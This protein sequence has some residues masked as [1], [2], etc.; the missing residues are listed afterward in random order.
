MNRFIIGLLVL[1]LLSCSQKEKL[2]GETAWQKKMNADFKDASKSPLKKKDLKNFKSLD[3]FPFDS[4]YVVR[5]NLVRTPDSEWFNMKTSTG[6]VTVERIYGVLHF[7][8][9]G[10]PF[11]LNVYE[12][13]ESMQMGRFN[14]YLF[15]PFLDDTNGNTTYAGGR[16]INLQIPDSN[17][18]TINFNMAYSP[19]CD[20]NEKYSCP[21]VPRVNYLPTEVKA[22]VKAYKKN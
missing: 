6:D 4:S 2:L 11:Q 21:I 13:Q 12:G 22:G 16:Y 18:I 20:Y 5:A 19:Y 15:L 9:N 3:F 7:N 1:T 17:N 14:K 10:E 8:L